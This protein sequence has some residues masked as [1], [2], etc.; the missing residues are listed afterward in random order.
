M[1]QMR[2]AVSFRNHLCISFELLSINLYDYI[3]ANSF[4][5]SSLRL[6]RCAALCH[7]MLCCAVLCCAVHAVVFTLCCS[8]CAALCCAVLFYD[9]LRCATLCSA[10]WSCQ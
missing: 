5:G 2:E 1:V 4:K 6:I 8:R 10:V 3:K 7:D 9:V